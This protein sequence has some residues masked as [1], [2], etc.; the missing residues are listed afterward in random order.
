MN[1]KKM[2]TVLGSVT[3]IG[4]IGIGGT[5]AYLSQQTKVVSNVF[6][7]GNG[8]NVDLLESKVGT[9]P[10][11]NPDLL[12]DENGDFIE[13]VKKLDE[14]Y[15]WDYDGDGPEEEGEEEGEV[16]RKG[17]WTVRENVYN[18]IVPGEKVFK[19]PTVIMDA[20]SAD[21]YIYVTVKNA[22]TKETDTTT[23]YQVNIGE[24][25]DLVTAGGLPSDVL[26]YRYSGIAEAGKNY[27]LFTEATLRKD[28][29]ENFADENGKVTLNKL[30]VKAYAVQA[31]GISEETAEKEAIELIK[32]QP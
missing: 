19:D 7:I 30:D 28:V 4:A 17:N 8:L 20:D 9:E 23:Q 5:L 15:G 26:V 14:A 12:K 10:G 6:K 22:S 21:A 29:E 16:K 18:D 31:K 2:A 11:E 32:K 25:W 3:L 1:K 13:P 27:T 24:S